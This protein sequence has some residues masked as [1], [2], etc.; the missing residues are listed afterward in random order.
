MEKKLMTLDVLSSI[1][2]AKSSEA[3]DKLLTIIN[4]A[5]VFSEDVHLFEKDNSNI[6][7]IESLRDD[8]AIDCSEEEKGLIIQN[9]PKSEN[10]YLVVPKVIE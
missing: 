9:F 6:V 8:I 4:N 10:C 5:Q 7:G 3:I 2:G 1:K